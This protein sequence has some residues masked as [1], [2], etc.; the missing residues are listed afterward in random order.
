MEKNQTMTFDEAYRE[1]EKTV[2]AMENPDVS[3]EESLRL[4]QEAYRLIAYC[5]ELLK[6]AKQQIVDINEQI[7][8]LTQSPDAYIED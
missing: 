8:K 6:D 1:L 4:Y 2:L 5:Q 7:K 3:F